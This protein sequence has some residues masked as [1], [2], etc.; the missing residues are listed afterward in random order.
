MVSHLLPF[1]TSVAPTPTN[2]TTS[3]TNL[4]PPPSHYPAGSQALFLRKTKTTIGGRRRRP[5]RLHR[6]TTTVEEQRERNLEIL[7]LWPF[8]LPPPYFVLVF[9][10]FCVASASRLSSSPLPFPLSFPSI[11]P[12]AAAAAAAPPSSEAIKAERITFE[13]QDTLSIVLPGGKRLF[14]YCVEIC[15]RTVQ[16]SSLVM[17]F[18]YLDVKREKHCVGRGGGIALFR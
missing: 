3:L 16:P 9:H 4:S 13:E 8:L 15:R 10:L 1:S 5:T 12:A 6:R 14:P 11:P 17:S 18:I 2:K 7:P